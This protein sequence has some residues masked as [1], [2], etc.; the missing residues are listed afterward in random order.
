MVLLILMEV[1][2][3]AS[4]ASS[5]VPAVEPEAEEVSPEQAARLS[6]MAAARVNASAFFI[7]VLL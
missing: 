5:P 3:E 2:V 4:A 1:E 6:A 7:V